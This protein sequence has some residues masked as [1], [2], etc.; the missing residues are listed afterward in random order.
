M[1]R[2]VYWF[3][4]KWRERYA[5]TLAKPL[6]PLPEQKVFKAKKGL[7]ALDSYEGGASDSFWAKFP[8]NYIQP[9]PPS[10]D[11]AR[12]ENLAVAC[13]FKNR[14]L[15]DAILKDV[16]FGARIG[17]KDPFRAPSRS[18][19]APSALENGEKVTDAIACW[20]ASKFV[21]GPV[22]ISEVP[23]HAK[24]SGLMTR[25][26]PNGSVRVIQNMSAPKGFS[27]NDGIDNAEF[28]AVMSS[29][30]QWVKAFHKGGRR[31]WFCKIDW[32][33]AYKHLTVH[34]EDTDLQWF[35]WLNKAFKE[36]CL[37]FGGVSSAGLF[38]R[39]AKVVIFIVISRSGIH[40]DLVVQHLDDC[41]AV[42]PANSNILDKFD[43]EYFQVAELLGIKLAPRDDP[44]KSFGPSTSG[45]VLWVFYDSVDWSW[46]LPAEKLARLL[47]D[48]KE[49]MCAERVKQELV[50]RVVG[51]ILNVMPLV[52]TGRFNI[53]H[54]IRAN[55]ESESR[56]YLV[57]VTPALKRQLFFWFSILPAC[58]GASAIPNPFR[59][60][61]PWTIEVFTDAAGGSTGKPGH[62]VGAVTHG[63]WSYVPWSPAIN[64][65]ALVKDA[66]GRR[67]DRILSALELLGPLLALAAGM[68]RFRGRPVRFWVDNSGSVYIWK[69]GYSSSCRICTTVVKAM[70]SLAAT[71]GC[72]VEVVKITR[73]SEP[74]AVMADCLSKAAFGK[75]W[76][77]AYSLGGLDLPLDLARVPS[78]LTKWIQDP[79][80]DD[81]LGDRLVRQIGKENPSW[82]PSACL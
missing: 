66:S 50:W 9:A 42:G 11:A 47:H 14:G 28:P 56:R 62:G 74:L 40:P 21:Y 13:G 61:P 67:L 76:R 72:R 16:K 49:M 38:D 3:L 27:V 48:I 58:G 4:L 69:K 29:T 24:F 2:E 63:W 22:D 46:K 8:S 36:L 10:I 30:W 77:E 26:K 15:L 79:V 41:C 82:G 33:D 19:N 64:R 71:F 51:K 12:L 81:D 25:P 1:T 17:C 7:P 75:F 44:D 54:L 32:S 45:T 73:C 78:V 31:C 5:E 37:I 52:P 18:S 23:P 60:L 35:M 68:D 53:D 80:E 39:L 34:L 59:G 70:A 20:A 6:M 57:C 65:G 43:S 55:S